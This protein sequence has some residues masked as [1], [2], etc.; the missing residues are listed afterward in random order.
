MSALSLTGVRAA[1]AAALAPAAEGDPV[2]LP[3]LV[4][5]VDPP[6]LMLEW[7]DPWV[8]MQTVAGGLGVF[9]ASMNVLC[10][11][12]RIEPGPGIETLERLIDFTLERLQADAYSWP[13]SASQAPRVFEIA[14]IPLLGARLS[15]RVPIALNGGT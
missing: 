1:A 8:T 12:S 7:N 3:D 5:A 4:D 6:A 2:V 13:L 10:F 14:G 15:F 11:A 9:Y